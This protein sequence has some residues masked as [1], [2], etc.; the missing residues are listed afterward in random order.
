MCCFFVCVFINL[1]IIS[2][3]GKIFEDGLVVFNQH[4][5]SIFLRLLLSEIYN[6]KCHVVLLES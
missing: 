3:N 6:Q 5:P 4:I 1:A 2:L